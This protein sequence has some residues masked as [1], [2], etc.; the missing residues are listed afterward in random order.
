MSKLTTLKSWE[1]LTLQALEA[2]PCPD[3]RSVV[4]H[5]GITLNYSQQYISPAIMDHLL[6]LAN[7]THL[8]DHISALFSCGGKGP[9]VSLHVGLRALKDSSIYFQGRDLLPDMMHT[10]HLMY[11]M[12]TEIRTQ[13]WVGCTDQPITDIVHLGIGGSMLGTAFGLKA[14]NDNISAKQTFHFVSEVSPHALENTLKKLNPETTLFI[15]ASKSF[16]TKE[17]ICN[18]EKAISW[19]SCCKVKSQHLIA[20]TANPDLAKTYQINHVLNLSHMVV[21]RFSTFSAISLITCIA[22]GTDGYQAML[23]GAQC[24][25]QHFLD[26]NFSENLPVLLAL[27]GIWNINFLGIHQHLMLAYGENLEKLVPFVQQL[28]M[29]SNGKSIDIHNHRVDYATAPIVWGGAGYSA[30]HS[31]YQLIAQGTH[32]IAMDVIVDFN[33]HEDTNNLVFFNVNNNIN[34]TIGSAAYHVNQIIL[35]RCEP[36]TIGALIA[37]YEHKVFCQSV[38][39]NINPFNQPGVDCFKKFLFNKNEPGE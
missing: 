18:L 22:L 29:E 33:Y 9:D 37:L 23:D 8:H 31:Y 28:E 39:W 36:S 32:Q 10:R 30:Q 34:Q 12:A 5:H 17:T 21:G 15:V 27:I 2:R 38:I 16:R 35:N 24:M 7:D 6:N 25:D 20:V 14:L 26:A 11:R 4:T 13:Q 3:K 19:L 1:Q